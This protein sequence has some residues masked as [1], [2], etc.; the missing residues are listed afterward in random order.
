MND[1]EES[2]TLENFVDS[3][4]FEL[5]LNETK[6]EKDIVHAINRLIGNHTFLCNFRDKLHSK[7]AKIARV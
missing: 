7:R 5:L 2:A 3:F 1:E 6:D 4:I